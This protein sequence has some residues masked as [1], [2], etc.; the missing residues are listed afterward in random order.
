MGLLS[1]LHVVLRR[2][3]WGLVQDHVAVEHALHADP[4]GVLDAG[5]RERRRVC[6]GAEPRVCHSVARHVRQH[7]DARRAERHAALA[8]VGLFVRCHAGVAGAGC[9]VGARRRLRLGA[10]VGALGQRQTDDTGDEDGVGRAVGRAALDPA[11]D[12][13]ADLPVGQRAGA[14][15]GVDADH[16]TLAACQVHGQ[17]RRIARGAAA[18]DKLDLRVAERRRLVAAAALPDGQRRVRLQAHAAACCL[19]AAREGGIVEEGID[20]CRLAHAGAANNSNLQLHG[21]HFLE[22]PAEKLVA[23]FPL[24]LKEVQIGL[25]DRHGVRSLRQAQHN[26]RPLPRPLVLRPPRRRLRRRRRRRRRRAS[27]AA[28]RHGAVAHAV[29]R[30]LLRRRRGHVLA[31]VARRRRDGVPRVGGARRRRRRHRRRR[32][33]DRRGLAA[34]PADDVAAEEAHLGPH[35]ILAA[36][37]VEVAAHAAEAVEH[38]ARRQKLDHRLQLRLAEAPEAGAAD[39]HGADAHD[40]LAVCLDHRLLVVGEAAVAGA[41]VVADR[42]LLLD[43]QPLRATRVA[44]DLPADAAVVLSHDEGEALVAA[45]AVR[46]LAVAR[47]LARVHAA[48]LGPVVADG[49]EPG[50]QLQLQRDGG[51]RDGRARHVVDGALHALL[52][53]HGAGRLDAAAVHARRRRGHAHAGREHNRASRHCLLTRKAAAL[54]TPSA[55]RATHS[56]CVCMCVRVTAMKYRYC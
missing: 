39:G 19:E 38:V 8:R 9:C 51:C 31:R 32:G 56:R 55:P 50:V 33:G 22:A 3:H 30:Q 18:V 7:G 47:P 41:D 23:P 54:P 27:A 53:D 25:V 35:G 5:P 4:E 46:D 6:H 24:P 2:P 45:G 13:A 20:Q 11:R 1:L 34:A 21:K 40:A 29:A 10:L 28:L 17:E 48:G 49:G 14:S 36:L 42:L 43:H 26:R 52:H 12:A 37:E 16:H 15:D 44:E